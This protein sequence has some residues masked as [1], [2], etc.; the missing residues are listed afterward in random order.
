[1]LQQLHKETA[2]ALTES[3]AKIDTHLNVR[4]PL[5]QDLYPAQSLQVSMMED[6]YTKYMREMESQIGQVL[7]HVK[8]VEESMLYLQ[9]ALLREDLINS[10]DTALAKRIISAQRTF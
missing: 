8:E 10:R 7:S 3:E 1:L 4:R 6:S 2:K 5:E 9:S